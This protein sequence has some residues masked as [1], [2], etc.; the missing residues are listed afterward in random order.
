MLKFS[1]SRFVHRQAGIELSIKLPCYQAVREALGQASAVV[2]PSEAHGLLCG[3]LTVGKVQNMDGTLWV[4]AITSD[5][6]SD[7]QLAPDKAKVL[8]LLFNLTKEMFEELEFN[9]TLLVP[10]E[11]VALTARAEELGMWCQGYLSGLG[12]GDINLDSIKNDEVND[13][14]HKISEISQIDYE[15]LD[16]SE[17][18]ESA[19]VE[20][21]EFIRIAVMSLHLE[22][23]QYKQSDDGGHSGGHYH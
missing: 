1:T 17:A 21:S 6:E 4:R 22:V 7:V 8:S 9:F 10:E 13:I 16:V 2:S 14:L 18:D 15:H 23:L 11:D 5:L 19:F 3:L 20:V 12:L